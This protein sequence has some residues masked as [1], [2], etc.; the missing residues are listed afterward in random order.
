MYTTTVIV[1]MRIQK[2]RNNHRFTFNRVVCSYFLVYYS[3]IV[4][5]VIN[6]VKKLENI[7]HRRIDAYNMYKYLST[8][9]YRSNNTVKGNIYNY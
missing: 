4:G 8:E 6:N 5:I 7:K 3:H 2:S 1:V 9:C